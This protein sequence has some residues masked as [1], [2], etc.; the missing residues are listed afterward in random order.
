[1]AKRV[2]PHAMLRSGID[3][4]DEER[5]VARHESWSDAEAY[6]HYVGRWSRLVAGEFL[7]WLN[8]PSGM[9]W[10]DVG[11]G[12]GSLTRTILERAKPEVVR[13]I[14]LSPD[15]VAFAQRSIADER[16]SFALAD[17]MKLDGEPDGHY[18]AAVSGLVMNFVPEPEQCAR[19][20]SR[21]VRAGGTVACYVWDYAGEMQL[22][23]HFWDAV[24][25]LDPSAA[26]LDEGRRFPLCDPDR[27]QALWQSTGLGEVTT[28]AI[29]VSTVFVDFDDYWSPFLG[30]QGPAPGYAVSLDD[31][32]R[33]ELRELLR[34]RLPTSQDGSISLIARAWAVKGIC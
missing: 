12:A 28:R 25:E 20:M 14:D 24:V 19:E 23:R 32:A 27:L 18:D 31:E 11:C 5:I 30:G 8:L 26:E 13:G 16:A 33:R 22:M 1:M 10:L 2:H 9:R 34:S 29:D 4:N 7:D 15:Y 3:T 6:H 17:A 21:V